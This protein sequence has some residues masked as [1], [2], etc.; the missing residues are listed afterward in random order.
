MATA[1]RRILVVEDDKSLRDALER[2]LDAAG[3]EAGSYGSAEALLANGGAAD[4][5][6]VVSDLKLPAR[7]GLELLDEMRARGWRPP[8][9]L[10]TAHDAPGLRGEAE[11]HGVAAY[12]AKPF[13]GT[14][15]LDAIADVTGHERPSG[16]AGPGVKP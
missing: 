7:S 15:L 16:P 9:I 13:R 1:G 14:A 11:R 2:L 12:L 4:A 6:C 8:L 10:I 5:A 3:F